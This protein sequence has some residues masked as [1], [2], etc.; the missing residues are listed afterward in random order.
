MPDFVN[1]PPHYTSGAIECLDAIEAALGS[2]NFQMYCRGQVIKYL[3]RMDRK[4][5]P[6]E[7]SRK[8]QFYLNRMVGSME[9][10]A[11]TTTE[12]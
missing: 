9:L 5:M 12:P 2:Y 7:D 1:H 4:G 11:T 3:W 6:L 10:E 8:A